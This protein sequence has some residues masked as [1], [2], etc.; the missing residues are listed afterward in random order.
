MSTVYEGEAVISLCAWYIGHE[1][2]EQKT[3]SVRVNVSRH[4]N[5]LVDVRYFGALNVPNGANVAKLQ[6]GNGLE[7]EGRLEQFAINAVGGWF[8]LEIERLG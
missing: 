3:S 2:I 5:G 1:P 8:S 6:L 4:G 7:Y